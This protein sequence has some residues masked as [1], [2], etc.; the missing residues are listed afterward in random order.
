MRDLCSKF[1]QVKSQPKQVK[2]TSQH[3]NIS[4]QLYNLLRFTISNVNRYP[5]WSEKIFHQEF[6]I[7]DNLISFSRC[8]EGN[9]KFMR[10]TWITSHLEWKLGLQ[11]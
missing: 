5:S 6:N 10:G 1:S 2:H 11:D 3:S 9:F 8:Y 7:N 4:T